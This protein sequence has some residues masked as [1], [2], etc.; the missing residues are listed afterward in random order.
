MS[1]DKSRDAQ[2]K[3]YVTRQIGRRRGGHANKVN[4]LRIS[5]HYSNYLS[6]CSICRS[7]IAFNTTLR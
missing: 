7:A 3:K 2:K 4:A 6:A 1:V 5:L